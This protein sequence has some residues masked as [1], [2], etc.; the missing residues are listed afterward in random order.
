[1]MRDSARTLRRSAGVALVGTVGVLGLG[2]VLVGLW[3]TLTSDHPVGPFLAL[4]VAT[5]LLTDVTA[6]DLRV[7]RHAESFTWSEL[8]VV[9]GL[10]LLP[11]DHLLLTSLVLLIPRFLILPSPFPIL[12]NPLP[13]CHQGW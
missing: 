8:T 10:A 3:G 4:V 12:R 7:G 1:M 9:L 5:T 2:V 11:V 13:V 6:I